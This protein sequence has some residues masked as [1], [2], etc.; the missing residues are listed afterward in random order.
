MMRYTAYCGQRLYAPPSLTPAIRMENAMPLYDF[1]CSDCQDR[2]EVFTS[3][4]ASAGGI[5]CPRCQ[6]SRVRKLFSVF[7]TS[8]HGADAS[9][10]DYSDYSDYGDDGDYGGGCSC[11]GA[12][13]C[14]GH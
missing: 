3:Y 4:A 5:S 11:G 7:A 8:G 1:Y 10:G 2:F 12:C 6:G 13:S 9:A 14:G